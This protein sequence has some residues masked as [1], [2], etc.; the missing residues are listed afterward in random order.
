MLALQN[1]RSNFFHTL[2]SI[3][4]IVIG[5]AA[6]VIILSL[7]DGMEEFA[8]KQLSSTTSLKTLE[9]RSSTHKAVNGVRIQKDTVSVI[10]YDLF[11]QMN[12]EF[13]SEATL[14]LVSVHTKEIKSSRDDSVRAV[15]ANGI[16]SS[17]F[18]RFYLST[19]KS[20]DS[21]AVEGKERVVLLNQQAA[22]LYEADSAKWNTL[23]GD[24]LYFGAQKLVVQGV[25]KNRNT[26]P[27]IYLPFTLLSWRELK[28]SPPQCYAEANDIE[29]V[30]KLKENVT[31]WLS[32]RAHDPG[33]FTVATNEFRVQQAA[34]GFLLFRIIMGMIVGVAVLVGGIGVMNVLLISVTERTVE[35]GV[36]KAVGANRRDIVMQFLAESVTVSVFGSLI[37]LVLGVLLTMIAVPVVKMIVDV[38]FY[39]AYTWNTFLVVSVIAVL[40]GV[41]FGTYPAVRASKLDPVE[42]IRRE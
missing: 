4:G 15:V 30:T 21:V 29:N 8:Q 23:V 14:Y 12:R 5:V 16:S 41:V 20:F 13:S 34:K 27:E 31:Q 38:P 6:L 10:D 39:A 2:L 7:I 33:D 32:K 22:R 3:L 36:R 42:A 19:G 26:Q 37:G 24:T 9:I 25:V 40:I 28:A 1:I 35:I 18:Q 11:Q 17:V